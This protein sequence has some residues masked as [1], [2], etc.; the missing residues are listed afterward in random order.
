MKKGEIVELDSGKEVELIRSVRRKE[1][2]ENDY[3]Q[4]WEVKDENGNIDVMLLIV[5]KTVA[6]ENTEVRK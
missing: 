3:S 5:R 2:H 6:N 1:Q 4:F